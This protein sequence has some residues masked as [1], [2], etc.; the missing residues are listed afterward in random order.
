MQQNFCRRF[1]S[2]FSQCTVRTLQRHICGPPLIGSYNYMCHPSLANIRIYTHPSPPTPPILLIFPPILLP[3]S[4]ENSG[5]ATPH[6]PLPFS[7]STLIQF[8][9]HR[10]QFEAYQELRRWLDPEGQKD[11]IIIRETSRYQEQNQKICDIYM[12][13][14]GSQWL[15]CIQRLRVW[16]LDDNFQVGHQETL[17]SHQLVHIYYGQI[18]CGSKS[19][20]RLM[21]KQTI[22]RCWNILYLCL[23]MNPG[24]VGLHYSGHETISS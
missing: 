5:V 21:A 8:T 2:A 11:R 16:A 14:M 12:S 1:L 3:S 6:L 23:L 22:G 10:M 7:Y 18:F 4:L 19:K 24:N 13:N 15:Y 20:T 9:Q 17:Y